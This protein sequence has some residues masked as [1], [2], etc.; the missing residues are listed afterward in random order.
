MTQLEALNILKTGRSVFLTGSAGSGKT[1]LLNKYIAYIRGLG[2]D[3]AIT[4]STGIAATHMGGMTI[5][6]WSGLGIS[7]DLSESDIYELLDRPHLKGR[8]A[9]THVLIIDE[10]SMLHDFQLDL[11]DAILRIARKNDE[12]FGGMQVIFCGDFFQLPP[13]ARSYDMPVAFA[14]SARSW[15]ERAPVVC[16]LEEQHRQKEGEL[17]DILNAMRSHTVEDKHREILQSRMGKTSVSHEGGTKLFT[18]NVDVDTI[19]LRELEKIDGPSREYDMTSKGSAKLVMAVKKSC[20]APEKLLLKKGA[21]VM[22][23]KNNFEQGYVNGTLGTVI[24]FDHDGPIVQTLTGKRIKVTTAEWRIDD[25]GKTKALIS[26]IPLR[27]AWAITVHK[28]QGMSLDTAEIDLSKC[29]EPGMGYVALSRV[30][31]L[32][33]LLLSGIN[34]MAFAVHPDV[35]EADQI[36]RE[37]S[38]QAREDL[39]ALDPKVLKDAQDDFASKICELAG[40]KSA[41]KKST[42]ETTKDYLLAGKSISTIARERDLTKETVIDHVEKLIA[43]GIDISL[44][45]IKKEF[46]TDKQVKEICDGFE[47]LYPETRS[48]A[49][50]PVK[51]KLG[52]K[53]TFLQLRVARL[54]ITK[55]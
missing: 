22:F 26:Q 24:G 36:F 23:V 45:L 21:R 20:L 50:S 42:I 3:V 8:F 14:F 39:K 30:R 7:D 2:G 25:E 18:H 6:A 13:I 32:E 49:L 5:H 12:P 17:L 53:Y 46:L 9:R 51:E 48:Y 54:F 11:V 33:G 1:Y 19:N 34:D 4:A 41:K 35:H 44:T 28:S 38:I 27:L 10:V 40:T 16:Y 55:E 15:K 37:A 43:G 47:E 52:S 29:F 31:S